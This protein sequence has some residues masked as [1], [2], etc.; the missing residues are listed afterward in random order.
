VLECVV[1]DLDGLLVDSEPLQFRAYREAFALHGVAIDLSDWRRWQEVE[2]SVPRWVELDGLEVDPEAVRADKK[3]L[4]E[5]LVMQELVLKPGAGS[6]V[7]EAATHCRLCV[8]SGSRREA[9]EACLGKFGLDRHFESFFSGTELERS[10]PHPDVYVHA[11]AS[12]GVAAQRALAIED[13]VQGLAAAS[14]A[15]LQCVVCPDT[16]HPRPKSDFAGAA[17]L[18]DSLEELNVEVLERILAR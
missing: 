4:Y 8:A 1:F 17:L 10:K 15:G 5:E 16:Q 18:V 14:A 9:I 6:L 12:M 13:S 2:A 7:R 11:L 3:A